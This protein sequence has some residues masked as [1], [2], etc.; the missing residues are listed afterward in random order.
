MTDLATIC[1][2]WIRRFHPAPGDGTRLVVLP[3]AGGS[4]SFY[5]PL[6]R[7]LAPRFDVPAVQYPGCQVRLAEPCIDD[8]GELADRIAAVLQP[9]TC[10][11][12]AF[13]GHSMGALV[14][15]EVARR[16]DVEP[17]QLFVSGRRAPSWYR[18]ERVHQ[19]NGEGL[20]AELRKLSGTASW[21][22]GDEELLR[23]VLPAVRSDYRAVETYGCAPGAKVGCPITVLVG[24]ADPKVTL[25][26]VE[27]WR[28]HTEAE[29]DVRVF[30]GGHFF[31]TERQDEVLAVITGGSL[32]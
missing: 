11:P 8:I 22:L 9:W 23:V 29:A 26:E 21:V 18:D 17:I 6:S 28:E 27:A 15:F 2:N 3:H 14:A 4:A 24:D 30:S 19:R 7:A 5:F 16:L 1:E 13:F 32:R 12:P 25:D 10:E 31:M 20:V